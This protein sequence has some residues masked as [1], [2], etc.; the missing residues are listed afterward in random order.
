MQARWDMCLSEPFSVSNGVRQ[1]S[2]ISPHLFAVYLDGLLLELCNSGVG[3]YWGCSFAGG[4]SYAD[5]M[6][7]Y[8]L[9]LR[10]H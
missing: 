2:V 6:V 3:C 9:R 5:N 8:W 4:F 1:G 7:F 10:L